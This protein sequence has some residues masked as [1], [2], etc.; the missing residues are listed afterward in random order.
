MKKEI[1]KIVLG[2]YNILHRG[3]FTPMENI[4]RKNV[5]LIISLIYERLST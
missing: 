4:V 1:E 3:V 2:T 5:E